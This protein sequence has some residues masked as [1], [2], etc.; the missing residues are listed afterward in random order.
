VALPFGTMFI[1]VFLLSM[2]GSKYDDLE[3]LHQL[4]DQEDQEDEDIFSLASYFIYCNFPFL[5]HYH[6]LK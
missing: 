1:S 2:Q 3:L 6:F 4:V 5:F